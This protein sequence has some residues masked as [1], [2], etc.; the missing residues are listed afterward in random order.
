MDREPPET[1]STLT[2]PV[3]CRKVLCGLSATLALLSMAG[4]TIPGAFTQ[5]DFGRP[6][7]AN[8]SVEEVVRRVNKNIERLQ[9]WRSNSV[10]ISGESLPVH[11]A[12]QISVE[13]P[14]NFRLTAGILGMDEE[15]DFGSNTDWF[16]FWVKRASANGKPSYVYQ[17]RH[18]DMSSSQM[19]SQIPFQPD[20]LMEA[21]GVVP[22]DAQHM[23]LHAE[24]SGQI[25][26]L[27][28]EVLSPSGQMVK[29][30]IRVDLRR[31]V[32]L[33]H[34]LHD[35]NGNLIA[36]A[37]LD[38]HAPDKATG[39]IMP[40]LIALEWPEAHLQINLDITQIDVN[41]TTIPARNWEVPR[42]GSYY[43]AFDIGAM[44]RKRS[45]L[46]GSSAVRGDRAEPVSAAIDNS[47]ASQ[48]PPDQF[49]APSP[50]AGPG[51]ATIGLGN[52]RGSWP[53]A[54]ASS[55]WNQPIQAPPPTSIGR[56]RAA[57]P[58]F[59]GDPTSTRATTAPSSSAA[60]GITGD[61]PF[62]DPPPVSGSQTPVRP[63]PAGFAPGTG[64]SSSGS[65]SGDPFDSIPR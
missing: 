28:S 6:L 23:T 1:T 31:G 65:N 41:P 37:R 56:P 63:I 42:K 27:I 40:H 33:S 59:D 13:R 62:A 30:M 60:R 46:A 43:P 45:H 20:W 50:V 19:L 53:E 32:V 11:L 17:A 38:K 22:I 18:E 36:R 26:N 8:A 16:W 47:S 25:V 29:K 61:N 64:S 24:P 5:H 4:C 44:N 54:D 12:G 49:G 58:P 35:S 55:E 2:A 34:S 51:R 10:R 3:R 21:L 14:R 39:I 57:A 7:P 52:N 48:G 15:A 9:A